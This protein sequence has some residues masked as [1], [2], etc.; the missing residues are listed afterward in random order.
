MKFRPLALALA[1]STLFGIS[2][3]SAAISGDEQKV[4][5]VITKHLNSIG[6]EQAR[7]ATRSRLVVG[8]VQMSVRSTGTS[9]AAGNV[10]LASVANKNMITMKFGMIEY[11]YEK[12]GFDGSQVTAY[13]LRPGVYSTLGGFARTYTT[14]LREGLMAGTLSSA[15]PLLNLADRKVK[16]EWGGNKKIDSRSVV[17]IKYA[18]KGGSDLSISLYFDAENY[19]HVRTVYK[20]TIAARL[21]AGGIDSSAQQNETRYELTEDFSDFKEEQGLTLPHVYQ[22]QYK[23]SGQ[24][25]RYYDYVL[26]LHSFVFD[27]AIDVKDFNVAN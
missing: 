2:S 4:N 5:D 17:E 19:R 12:V 13:A 6:T 8:Q 20:K 21:G 16:L 14:I 11:P 10:V 18:P 23:Y 24:E 25:S 7:A 22:I 27:Q 26:N 9:R 15:W 1:F 3:A